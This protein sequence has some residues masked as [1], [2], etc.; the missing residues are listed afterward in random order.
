MRPPDAASTRT[1]TTASAIAATARCVRDRARDSRPDRRRVLAARA[2]DPARVRATGRDRA[3]SGTDRG[4]TLPRAS[5]TAGIDRPG[6]A[7]ADLGRDRDAAP[8]PVA[9]AGSAGADATP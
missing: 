2:P 1:A 5:V 8:A 3:G 9:P 4:R 7:A 6:A